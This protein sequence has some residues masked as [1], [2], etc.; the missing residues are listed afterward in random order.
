MNFRMRVCVPL[1]LTKGALQGGGGMIVLILILSETLMESSGDQDQSQ[2]LQHQWRDWSVSECDS[3]RRS[4]A[5][6]IPSL[7]VFG[8]LGDEARLIILF[9]I[10]S[11]FL[12]FF[13]KWKN[14]KANFRTSSRSF[15][16]PRSLGNSRELCYRF[17]LVA[18]AFH[19]AV[20]WR[21]S[22]LDGWAG[23]RRPSQPESFGTS[24][25]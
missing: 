3:C 13:S 19:H 7:R 16:P 20:T 1:A 6:I 2:A 12:F 14:V 4:P 10:L 5:H 11:F 25:N 24:M 21:C 9:D 8:N 15:S 23:S 17:D 22:Y 18:A